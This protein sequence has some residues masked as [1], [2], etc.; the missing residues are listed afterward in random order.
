MYGRLAAR[1]AQIVLCNLLLLTRIL[2]LASR[3]ATFQMLATGKVLEVISL[4][5]LADSLRVPSIPSSRTT[6]SPAHTDPCHVTVMAAWAGLV[7][8]L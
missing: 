2:F 8:V 7:L 5:V 1:Q 4:S 6:Q 3:S